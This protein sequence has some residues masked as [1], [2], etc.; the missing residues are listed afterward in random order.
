MVDELIEILE[1]FGY[2][3]IRQGSM[4]ESEEYYD[5]FFTFWENEATEHSHYDNSE[6]GIVYDFDI[7]VYSNDPD[8]TYSLLDEAKKKL[9]SLGW[10]FEDVGHDIASDVETHTGRGMNGLYVKFN[11]IEK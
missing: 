5:T 1:E 2:P 8:T 10:V 9:K 3:V 6:T 7:N 4:A 11:V